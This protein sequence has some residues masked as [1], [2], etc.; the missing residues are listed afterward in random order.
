[1]DRIIFLWDSL[2]LYFATFVF[3]NKDVLSS[4]NH[5]LENLNNP[6]FKIYLIFL[7]YILEIINQMNLQFQSEST[8]VHTLYCKFKS[9]YKTILKN[10]VK[11]SVLQ[12]TDFSKISLSNPDN[13]LNLEDGYMGANVSL[14]LRENNLEVM[15]SY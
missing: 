12:N 8:Q 7:S 2:K 9:I 4:N 11:R 15:I 5:L 6:V 3:E 10:F 14:Y 13:Y 1:M